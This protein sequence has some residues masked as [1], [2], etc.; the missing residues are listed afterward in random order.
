MKPVLREARAPL[1]SVENKVGCD[2]S[3]ERDLWTSSFHSTRQLQVSTLEA[4]KSKHWSPSTIKIHFHLR[5]EGE[6]PA[7]PPAA[8]S[9][10][11]QNKLGFPV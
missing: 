5:S 2:V 7:A 10:P 4:L 9:P 8:C 11:S 6:D 1:T 3:P